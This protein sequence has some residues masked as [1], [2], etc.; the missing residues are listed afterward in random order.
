MFCPIQIS[1]IAQAGFKPVKENCGI[2][3]AEEQH[4][5]LGDLA[6]CGEG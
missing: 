2:G 1:Q 5:D 3:I 6:R 4:A